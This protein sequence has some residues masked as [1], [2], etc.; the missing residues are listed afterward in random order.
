MGTIAG[1][2]STASGAI[3]PRDVD[4]DD[5]GTLWASRAKTPGKLVSDAKLKDRAVA[6]QS[7]NRVPQ[8]AEAKVDPQ[9]NRI[10][11]L[12]GGQVLGKVVFASK[13]LG[14]NYTYL[15]Q[16]GIRREELGNYLHDLHEKKRWG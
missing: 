10:V 2:W 9:R 4:K 3:A 11:L 14:I 8:G 1:A 15:G 13:E 5:G 12:P 6:V 16:L 7:F